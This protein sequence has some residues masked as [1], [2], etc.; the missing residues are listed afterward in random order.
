M[1]NWNHKAAMRSGCILMLAAGFCLLSQ[2]PSQAAKSPLISGAESTDDPASGPAVEEYSEEEASAGEEGNQTVSYSEE[3]LNDNLIEYG[4]LEALLR[5]GNSTVKT[6]VASYENNLANYQIAYD[7]LASARRDML[8]KADGLEEEGGDPVLINQYESSA[9]ML[10]SSAKQMKKRINSLSSATSQSTLKRSIN[11][12]VKSAQ[13]VMCSY[14]EMEYQV[15]AIGK[16]AEAAAASY[17]KKEKERSAGLATEEDLLAAEKTLLSA[18]ISLQ[19][20]KDSADSLKRQLAVLIGR[21]AEELTIGEIPAA[22]AQELASLDLAADKAKAVIADSTVKSLRSSSAVGD[23]ARKLRRQKLN[24]AEGEENITM[25]SLYQSVVAGSIRYDAALAAY[26]AAEREYSAL[27][28]KYAAGLI[29]RSEYLT[30]EADYLDEKAAM[31]SASIALNQALT[32]YQ[33]EKMG[34]S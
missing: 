15:Q 8:D 9:S 5:S 14:K 27:Q 20:A 21:N 22:D 4:E 1:W 32:A 33:W 18:R 28:K 24:E 31:E 2:T 3:Q 10:S 16:R 6:A 23:T 12:V 11:A 17:E 19:S 25:D 30:G 34:V 13:T 29:N 26:K 7:A